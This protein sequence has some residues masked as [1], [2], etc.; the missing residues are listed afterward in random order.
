MM[1]EEWRL[2]CSYVG[3]NKSGWFLHEQEQQK[4]ICEIEVQTVDGGR[5]IN[6]SS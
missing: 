6:S 4:P 5:Q 2:V 3:L 1:L